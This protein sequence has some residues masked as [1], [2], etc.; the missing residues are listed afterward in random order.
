MIL[1]Q[2]GETLSRGNDDFAIGGIQLAGQNLQEGR[3]SCAVGSDKAVA[4]ALGKFD[5]DIFE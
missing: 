4:V 5:I 1:L 3:L 2:E